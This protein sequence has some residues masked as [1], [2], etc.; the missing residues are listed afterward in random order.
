MKEKLKVGILGATGAVGQNYAILLEDHPRFE[1]SYLAASPNSAGKTYTEAVNGKWFMDRDI[2]SGLKK[3][4][5]GNA[6]NV[7]D[8]I[9]KC[10]FVFSSY[11]GSKEEIQATEMK[12][13]AA[14]IPVISN[15]SGHRWT[16]DVAMFIPEINS[17]HLSLIDIQ[18]KKRGFKKGFVVTKPNCSIQSYMHV[19]DALKRVGYFPGKLFVVTEQAL[20]GA[21]YPGVASLGIMDNV[22]PFISGEDEKTEKEPLKIFGKIENDKLI[23]EDRLRIHATCTRVPV[24]D[25]HLATV[26]AEFAKSL[27]SEKEIIEILE[28]YNPLRNL[29]L[30]SSPEKLIIYR[31]EEDRPQPRKDRSSGRGM[32]ITIG[33]IKKYQDWYDS[34]GLRFI[35]L[36]H[37]TIRGAAGGAILTAELLA[38]TG[39]LSF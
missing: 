27:P 2:P 5:L 9:G 29:N 26:Y 21:G 15:N 25:G 36:S 22:I 11:E 38:S 33:R 31:D 23:L 1:V 18:K 39:Y 13:A 8:A 30:P 4:V 20:S 16:E 19:I 28:S 24:I 35:G 3:I 17:S 37:N 34:F 14:E 6:S 10:D 7:D 32:A 12:Y